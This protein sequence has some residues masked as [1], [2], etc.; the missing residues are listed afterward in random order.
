M[1]SYVV[2]MLN[3]RS[4]VM[5]YAKWFNR[6]YMY[7]VPAKPWLYLCVCLN[8]QT[9]AH[10]QKQKLFYLDPRSIVREWAVSPNPSIC[11]SPNL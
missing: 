1:I 9:H 3:N 7:I 11:W 8:N 5:K 2:T 4:N 10:L 6:F